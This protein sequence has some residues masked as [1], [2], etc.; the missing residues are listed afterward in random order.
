MAVTSETR[1]RVLLTGAAGHIGSQIARLLVREGH[2]VFAIIRPQSDRWRLVGV[3]RDLVIV[4][5]DIRALSELR[6]RLG[7]VRPDICLHLA[8][9]G[10]VG[11]GEEN[12]LSLTASLDLM[13]MMTELSCPRFVAAGTCFEY[14]FSGDAVAE[15]SPLRPL[16]LY[17][18][19]K[20][21]LFDIS[22]Q[23]SAFSGLSVANPRIFNSY[24]PFEDV[25]RLVPCV[26][27]SLLRN[28][29][30]AVTSGEQI[31]DYLHVQDVA[32]AIWHVAKS[33]VTGAVNIASGEPVSV[34]DLAM[35]VGSLLGKLHMVQLGAAPSRAQ[36]PKRILGDPTMLRQRL[37]WVPQFDLDRGLTET[38]RWWEDRT[39]R[40]G[41]A[42]RS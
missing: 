27:Q 9:R 6:S 15:T 34:A 4:D 5:G 33:D 30:A 17:A 37:G 14:D 28:E 8:W 26:A 18:N 22:Q 41:S 19:C 7:T 1:R 10:W 36:E 21:A 40:E 23:W 11:A 12:L 39:R 29:F 3:E 25:R 20:R 32:S 24:G 13:W 2:E 16:G 42:S 35:R 31:R 38:V